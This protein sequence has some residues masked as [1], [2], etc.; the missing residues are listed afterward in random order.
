MRALLV[1]LVAGVLAT[2]CGKR[3]EERRPEPEPEPEIVGEPG[4]ESE[5]P[6]EPP[7]QGEIEIEEAQARGLLTLLEGL[8]QDAPLKVM[9]RVGAHC[10]SV[11][12]CATPDC[13]QVLRVCATV[14]SLED[15][16]SFLVLGCPAFQ[17]EAQTLS[18]DALAVAT[19]GWIQARY[20]RLIDRARA[21]LGPADQKALDRARARLGL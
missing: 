14:S 3:R 4:T 9:T 1:L 13:A 6:T 19:R 5:T 16:G 7:A 15:C 21:I 18:G 10:G 8:P 17:V 11:P 2:G 12:G 20:A